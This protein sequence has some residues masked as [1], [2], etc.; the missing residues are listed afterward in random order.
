MIQVRKNSLFYATEHGAYVGS[1]FISLIATCWHAK[2]NPIDYLVTLQQ[3][4]SALFQHPEK[5]LPWNYHLNPSV[6]PP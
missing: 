1:M 5:W 6:P 2:V 3:N 4:R